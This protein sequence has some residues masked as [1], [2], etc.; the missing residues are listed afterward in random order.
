MVLEI[1][2]HLID[3]LAEFAATLVV[4]QIVY[5]TKRQTSGALR[6][7]NKCHSHIAKSMGDAVW[8][9][10]LVCCL[11]K[12]KTLVRQSSRSTHTTRPRSALGEAVV[13]KTTY[14]HICTFVL[15]AALLS[16]NF[17]TPR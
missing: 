10:F 4:C 8:G 11:A 15:T 1:Q 13:S 3:L 12:L 2:P 6:Q 9:Y 14:P 16:T 17:T 5:G 7:A